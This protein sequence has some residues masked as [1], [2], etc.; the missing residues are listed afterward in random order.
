MHARVVSTA[1]LFGLHVDERGG[2]IKGA[3]IVCARR[4]EQ[5]GRR[6]VKL[7]G[8]MEAMLAWERNEV[9]GPAWWLLRS[10]QL[11]GVRAGVSGGLD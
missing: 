1:K 7:A 8:V 11:E 3:V 10:G 6:L 9:R 4:P 2:A 5:E